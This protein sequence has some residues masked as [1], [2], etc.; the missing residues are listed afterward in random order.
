MTTS[1]STQTP[2]A[3]EIASQKRGCLFFIGRGLK[4][5]GIILITLIVLGVAFQ[6][7]AT[8]LDKQNYAPR[9]QLYSVNGHQMHLVCMGEGSPAVI[10]AS[11]A[12]AESLWWYRVQNQLA[13]HTQ[14][15]AY[16]RPG[17]GWSEPAAGE[18]D[19]LTMTAELHTLLEAAGI[20]APYVIVGHSFGGI[21]TRIYAQQYPGDV[22]GIVLV[23]SQFVTPKQFASPGEFDSYKT[24]F[25]VT[26]AVTS[27]VTRI[28]LMRLLQPAT[29][30]NAGYPP[31]IA[32][33]MTGLQAR[34]Q[35]VDAYYAENGPAFPALQ[36]ASAA[37]ENLG[38]LPMYVLWASLSPSYHER[39]SAARDEIAAA[40]SN[41]VTHIVEGADHGSILGN[42]GYA[43][44]VSNAVLE[45]V[46]AVQTGRTAG[47]VDQ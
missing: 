34:S 1:V 44:Q 43:Q 29:F 41:S 2:S 27:V 9:G 30:Q 24:F 36:E 17:M 4:W 35:V 14:V 23:D 19:A 20:P 45:A 26:Q 10:L 47:T 32:L 39:F 18:R 3:A 16:D 22:A 13:E 15:C 21:L 7:I 38:D 11:G 28:G 25:D 6:T 40:S 31:D 5:F 37:A 33:E 42:E 8:E 46:E 12:V